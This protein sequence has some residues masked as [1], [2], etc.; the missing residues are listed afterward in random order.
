MPTYFRPIRQLAW[1]VVVLLL[2]LAGAAW[3]VMITAGNR[4]GKNAPAMA[5]AWQGNNALAK[6][7]IASGLVEQSQLSP[8][9]LGRA[10]SLAR[11]SLQ[12]QAL[13]PV[14]LRVL[15]F[16]NI[17]RGDE[18]R[19]NQLLVLAE[20]F[21]RRD[22]LTQIL[23]IEAR[24]SANDI[25]GALQ[26]YDRALRVSRSSAQTLLPVLTS[27]TGDPAVRERLRPM[28]A[29]RP[30]WLPLFMDELGRQKQ[31]AP[32]ILLDLAYA[33]GLQ[34]SSEQDVSL[35]QQMVGHM[36]RRGGYTAA[37]TLLGAD[38]RRHNQVRNGGFEHSNVFPPF[39]WSFPNLG[40]WTAS[41]G[42]VL[43]QGT[44]LELRANYAAGGIIAQQ[45]LM[46]TPGRYALRY[47]TEQSP[48][49]ESPKIRILCR[50]FG[51]EH[52]LVEAALA[53][54]SKPEGPM[55]I[56]TVPVSS[57]TEQWVQIKGPPTS[58][59]QERW[60]DDISVISIRS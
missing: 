6:A 41:P 38:K 49:E 35:V 55:E 23:L 29:R 45:L 7:Q 52:L 25:A 48:A 44:Q 36:I 11:S 31:I 51:K 54:E 58:R 26:H 21:S 53:S 2:V 47:R 39:D 34:P 46:L 12:R 5:L 20:R 24:V 3:T 18:Q 42:H 15:A 32:N 57:C 59:R 40:G 4:W 19:A 33:I 28:L 10:E 60:V 13:N 14:A 30:Q 1:L 9:D 27:A 8:D 22:A 16:A 43:D 37:R 17:H 56:F 50:K